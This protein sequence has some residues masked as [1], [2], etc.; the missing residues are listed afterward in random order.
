[1]FVGTGEV[2][3]WHEIDPVAVAMWYGTTERRS[4]RPKLDSAASSFLRHV[5][6]TT[7]RRPTP[8][9]RRI[10][11]EW[12]ALRRSIRLLGNGSVIESRLG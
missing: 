6:T 1:M 9:R 8:T 10:S 11:R 2:R 12:I 3:R 7:C 5:R 4:T